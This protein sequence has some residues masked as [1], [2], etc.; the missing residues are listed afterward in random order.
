MLQLISL[1]MTALPFF[2]LSGLLVCERERVSQA[3]VTRPF[4]EGWNRQT[5]CPGEQEVETL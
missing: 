2:A 3:A 4:A 5:L 1:I